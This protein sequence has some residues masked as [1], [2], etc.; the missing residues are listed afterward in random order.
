MRHLVLAVISVFGFWLTG[1][2]SNGPSFDPRSPVQGYTPR[3]LGAMTN[4]LDL[5]E[6][7]FT[8]YPR[9]Q[10]LSAEMLQ[11]PTA[12]YRLGP[13]DSIDVEILGEANSRFPATVGPDGKIYYGLLPGTFVWG[14]T[15]GETKEVLEK[16]LQKY[17]RVAPDVTVTLRQV[18]SKTVWVLGN[19]TTPGVYP[20]GTP[21]TLLEAITTAGGPLGGGMAGGAPGAALAPEGIIDLQRSF[22]MREGKMLPVS[23][24]RLLRAGDFSQNIY[25]QPN[26]FVYLRS[27]VTRNVYV[28]GAVT[29][30]T[31]LPY[32][33]QL[34]LAGAIASCQGTVRYAHLAQ[35]A[36]IRGS[37]TEPRVAVV[38]FKQ[39]MNGQL[40]D[41]RLQPGDIVYVPYVPW[42]RVAMLLESMLDSFVLTTA[43]NGAYTIAYPN[44][45]PYGPSVPT[46]GQAPP[47]VVPPN[48]GQ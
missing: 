17:V 38:D 6:Q 15:L 21:L 5:E 9:A 3:E 32:Q 33:D 7:A 41:V 13:G 40:P 4:T 46:G 1:C 35:V 34:S 44:A 22:V 25:L 48:P 11:P 47:P 16:G 24:D 2:Q 10:G 28:I 18:N 14:L 36:V 30:P 42:R 29:L 12:P 8:N 43:A 39:I 31:I 26:D 19:V 20:L 37:L 23:F 27:G 45:I